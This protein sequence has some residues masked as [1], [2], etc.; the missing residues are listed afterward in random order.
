LSQR[1][2][3]IIVS[4]HADQYQKTLTDACDGFITDYDT[5]LT[6]AL[7]QNDQV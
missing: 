6:D 4:L 3:R 5:R 2:R 7:Q 1:N